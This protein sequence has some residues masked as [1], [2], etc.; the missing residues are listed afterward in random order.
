VA[1]L[2][3]HELRAGAGAPHH[4]AALAELELDVV[5]HRADGDEFHWEAVPRLDV[6]AF[7]AGHNLVADLQLVR[8][9]DVSALAVGVAKQGQARRAVRIVLDRLDLR[10]HAALV[11]LEIDKPETPFV[12]AAA[13]VAGHAAEIVPAAALLQ[14]LNQALLGLGLGNL[15]EAETRAEPDAVR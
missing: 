13:V 12:A 10:R 6:D 2:L 7:L 11:A 5:D 14:R 9:Q 3:G 1:G 15:F 8:R 4:L